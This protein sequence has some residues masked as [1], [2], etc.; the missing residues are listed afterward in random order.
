MC[1]RVCLYP[2]LLQVCLYL[3]V[4]RLR[5]TSSIRDT[6]GSSNS[7][8]EKLQHRLHHGNHASKDSDFIAT[9]TP[10]LP[11]LAHYCSTASPEASAALLAVPKTQQLTFPK[12]AYRVFLRRRFGVPIPQRPPR[13]CTCKPKPELDRLGALLVCVCPKD[14]ERFVIHDSMALLYPQYGKSSRR[15]CQVRESAPVPRETRSLAMSSSPNRA[16]RL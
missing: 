6:T 1:W 7:R 13:C 14:R 9:T 11:S 2:S 10:T 8:M 5:H 4:T 16:A 12:Q 15:L 3:T